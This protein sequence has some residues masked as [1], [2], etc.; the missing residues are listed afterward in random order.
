MKHTDELWSM[1]QSQ[2]PLNPFCWETMLRQKIIGSQT[3][4]ILN[5]PL[6]TPK[7]IAIMTLPKQTRIINHHNHGSYM[8]ISYR[9]PRSTNNTRVPIYHGYERNKATYYQYQYYHRVNMKKL[10]NQASA[11]LLPYYIH[12][13]IHTQHVTVRS[14]H[15]HAVQND[16]NGCIKG[17]WRQK[18]STH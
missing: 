4:K 9:K 15:Y 3:N 18:Q 8:T 17:M 13:L 14:T 2:A 5:S 12:V 7:N 6:C 11:I 16:T 1:W 10:K